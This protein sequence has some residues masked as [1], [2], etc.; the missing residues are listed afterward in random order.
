MVAR[1]V[2]DITKIVQGHSMQVGRF[3]VRLEMLQ[4]TGAEEAGL[5]LQT[6]GKVRPGAD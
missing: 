3:V 6:F 1:F 2:T 4:D 5:G